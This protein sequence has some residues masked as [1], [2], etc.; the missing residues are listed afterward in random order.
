MLG[1]TNVEGNET[2]L[3]TMSNPNG[4]GNASAVLGTINSA[5]L[6]ILDDDFSPGTLA[7]STNAYTVA[8]NAGSLVVTLTRTGGTL[9]LVSVNYV[10]ANGSALAG[11]D[12]TTTSGTLSWPDGDAAAK[13]FSVTI[14]D[15]G[16]LE[17]NETFQVAIGGASGGAAL[18]VTNATVTIIDDDGVVQFAAANFVVFENATNA[19]VTVNRTG[20]ITNAAPVVVAISTVAGGSASAGAD[21]V[22]TNGSLTFATGV[23]SQTF[24]V[25]VL[26]DQ[27]AEPNETFNLSLGPITAGSAILGSQTNAT[28]T[29]VDNDISVQFSSANFCSG[30]R[31]ECHDHRDPDG[32]YQL[33]RRGNLRNQR[34]LRRVRSRLPSPARDT[35]FRRGENSKTFNITIL[36]DSVVEPDETV[37][38]RLTAPT[39]GAV[40]G[41]N[42]TATLTIQNDDTSVE[43]TAASFSVGENQTNALIS[44]RRLGVTTTAFGVSFGTANGTG[45]AGTHY[46]ATNGVL[47]FAS[48]ATSNAF[49]VRLI[50][51]LVPL[52][53]RTVNLSSRTLPA[54][55]S[56]ALSLRLCSPSMTM[57]LLCSSAPRPSACWRIRPMP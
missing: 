53:D 12:Y 44:L 19:V 16:V 34:W 15:D 45:V 2:V 33:I 21:F 1:D 30:G 55:R 25:S 23:T 17:G 49:Q 43:F 32:C 38:L 48:G 51:D 57:K 24:N 52:G 31:A 5:T 27:T 29:I 3:L 28:I 39:G 7:L 36:D 20:G 13:T 6:T 40:L 14:L 56:S 4:V 54:A 22:S 50:D 42:A 37:N 47:N 46:V 11:S 26:D 8:E 18:G 35:H 41:A 10:T 9:G